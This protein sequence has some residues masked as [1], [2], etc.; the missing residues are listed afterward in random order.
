MYFKSPCDISITWL[1]MP[2]KY[3]NV[4]FTF[5][6]EYRSVVYLHDKYI[7]IYVS[8]QRFYLMSQLVECFN[9]QLNKRTM[10]HNAHLKTVP[11]KKHIFAKLWIYH[12]ND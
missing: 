11:N 2:I 1:Y 8:D 7:T 10:G 3:G 5:Y 6:T 4:I 9:Y 12:N